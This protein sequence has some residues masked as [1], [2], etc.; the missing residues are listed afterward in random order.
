M[1][2]FKHIS[3][4]GAGLIGGSV[5]LATK[6]RG[7]AETFS[8]WSHSPS[9]LTFWSNLGGVTVHTSLESSVKNADLIVVATPVDKIRETFVKISP[10]L[11]RGALVTDVGSV[12]GS[13]LADASVL[14]SSIDFVGSHP[15]AGSE[16]AGA[17]NAHADLFDGRFCFITPGP[18]NNNDSVNNKSI[19][20]DIKDIIKNTCDIVSDVKEVIN[21]SLNIIND[22][23]DL[24]RFISLYSKKYVLQI[25]L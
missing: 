4:V 20:V 17:K 19:F 8:C 22:V 12:K 1:L 11:K 21:D 10:F 25:N 3:V 7:V 18:K 13:V 5:L 23:K 24:F 14:P 2:H 6:K 15:M 9:T 16:K